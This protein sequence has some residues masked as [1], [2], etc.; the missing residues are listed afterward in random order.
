[1]RGSSTRSAS[2]SEAVEEEGEAKRVWR[3][4]EEGAAKGTL[5]LPL[6]R[7]SDVEVWRRASL[8]ELEEEERKRTSARSEREKG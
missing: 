5:V 1:L 4:V 7:A 2:L 3:E 8:S 6:R